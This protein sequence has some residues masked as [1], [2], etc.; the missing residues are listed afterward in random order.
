MDGE[1]PL[2]NNRWRLD[3]PEKGPET[4]HSGSE[5][6]T[7]SYVVS[8]TVRHLESNH[9]TNDCLTAAWLERQPHDKKAQT[10]W[11]SCCQKPAWGLIDLSA[12][13]LPGH[14]A[15]PGC[16][17]VHLPLREGA[18]AQWVSCVGQ[19]QLTGKLTGLD[20]F[21]NPHEDGLVRVW[22]NERQV[23]P[24]IVDV[25]ACFVLQWKSEAT[26]RC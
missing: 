2:L 11:V 4:M 5:V 6:L 26:I 18:A 10:E 1:E 23:L 17:G 8:W 19:G 12:V 25:F 15:A 7:L 14:R 24:F 22:L 9:P 16:L 3:T 13:V 21:L 20:V